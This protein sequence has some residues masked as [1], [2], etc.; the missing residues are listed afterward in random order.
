MMTTDSRGSL[1]GLTTK[2]ELVFYLLPQEV[3]FNSFSILNKT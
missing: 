2:K 3:L 1:S